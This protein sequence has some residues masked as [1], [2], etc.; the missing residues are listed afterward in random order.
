MRP[1]YLFQAD[2]VKGIS[3]LR[4]RIEDGI[5]LVEKLRSH[6]SGMAVPDYVVDV[7]GSSGKIPLLP[8]HLVE[9]N[10][11]EVVLRN[12]EGGI[13]YYPQPEY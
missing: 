12:Y 5:C 7:P 3:H 9:T 2:P 4:T 1:Y 6:L 8:Q 11:K 10:E 13:Y